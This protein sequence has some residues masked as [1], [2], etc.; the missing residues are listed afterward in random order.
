MMIIT[1]F[2]LSRSLTSKTTTL[3]T[4][5]AR[6]KRKENCVYVLCITV[7]LLIGNIRANMS[8]TR[9][10][11]HPLSCLCNG[12]GY[13][14]THR[15]RIV[16]VVVAAAVVVVVAAAA[17]VVV[18]VAAAAAVAAVA[19]AAAVV[20]AVAVVVV[21]AV[22]AHRNKTKTVLHFRLHPSA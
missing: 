12:A 5:K 13:T 17:A 3:S 6:L 10:D 2:S 11:S 4:L 7:N 18:V 16:V 19:A 9:R 15:V 14:G 1:H 8:S 20:V 22:A 21:I